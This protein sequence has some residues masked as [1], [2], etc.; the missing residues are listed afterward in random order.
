MGGNQAAIQRAPTMTV[1]DDE[2]PVEKVFGAFAERLRVAD[3]SIVADSILE[4]LSVLGHGANDELTDRMIEYSW[5]SLH[6]V[7]A[8]AW[9][10]NSK[11]TLPFA[12]SKT[13]RRLALNAMSSELQVLRGVVEKSVDKISVPNRVFG[14]SHLRRGM[15]RHLGL[16]TR[17]TETIFLYREHLSSMIAE[18]SSLC[19]SLDSRSDN[20]HEEEK[21]EG[22]TDMS[23][24]GLTG[25]SPSIVGL[26]AATFSD[27]FEMVVHGVVV[28]AAVSD[29]ALL[30]GHK[31]GGSPYQH[32]HGLFALFRRLVELY[33]MH[34]PIFPRKTAAFVFSSSKDMLSVA[35]TQ[36]RRCV[37]WR[38]SQPLLSI[39]ERKVGK[40]DP[41]AILYLQQ[42]LDKMSANTASTA[43]SF[44]DFWQSQEGDDVRL[45][46]CTSLRYAAEKAARSIK[47]IA[48][49]HNLASPSLDREEVDESE[50]TVKSTK[51]FHH[52]GPDQFGGE[53]L[54]GARDRQPKLRRLC[55]DEEDEV[56]AEDDGS[57][58]DDDDATSGDSFGVAGDWG[59]ESSE[60]GSDDDLSL[61]LQSN[62]PLM[63]E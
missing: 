59:D 60:E 37:D 58:I 11:E 20:D 21:K 5:I 14:L 41:G 32:L 45:S 25:Q 26:E 1:V 6:T 38:N 53:Y 33:Q 62:F 52:L 27:F 17:S 24:T 43:L 29:P 10:E 18:L 8:D 54:F 30:V 16:L 12:L 56:M 15:L 36:L 22:E 46:R 28:T 49:A 7:Y 48:S 13:T 39:A 55:I 35:V 40:H 61:N 19:E 51:G 63:R 42:L 57:N 47:D 34:F 50:E 4:I 3:N 2:P 23:A 31:G 9:I 44:C